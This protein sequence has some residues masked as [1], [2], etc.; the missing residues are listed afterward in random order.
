[1][2]MDSNENDILLDW[3]WWE[4]IIIEGM[5]GEGIKRKGTY[6]WINF[7]SLSSIFS[8]C[9]ISFASFLSSDLERREWLGS[10]FL[11]AVKRLFL[12]WGSRAADSWS[13]QDIASASDAEEVQL[14]YSSCFLGLL[15]NIS[16]ILFWVDFY[17]L[18]LDSAC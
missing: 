8:L 16:S 14:L 17:N 2:D 6:Q 5:G 18:P 4:D 13:K 11:N 15:D 3:H 1:M 12:I 10:Y 7:K 9:P